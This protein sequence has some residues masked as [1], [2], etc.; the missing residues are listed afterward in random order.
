MTK[1]FVEKPRLHRVFKIRIHVKI[2]VKHGQIFTCEVLLSS[3]K[4]RKV[5]HST[6]QCQVGRYLV[7]RISQ[8]LSPLCVVC[9]VHL[10]SA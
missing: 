9:T 6:A 2:L 5:Q 3:G 7:V 4:A 1:L 10:C 8:M